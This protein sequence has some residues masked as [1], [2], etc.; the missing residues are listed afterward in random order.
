MTIYTQDDKPVRDGED[1]SVDVLIWTP[2][3]FIMGYYSYA[4]DTW[5]RTATFKV[6]SQDKFQWMYN[7]FINDK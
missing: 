1:L 3:D 2:N 7:P 4:D 6:I 5:R